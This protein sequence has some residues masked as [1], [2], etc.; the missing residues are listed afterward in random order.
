MKNTTIELSVSLKF[1]V[2]ADS[3]LNLCIFAAVYNECGPIAGL[4]DDCSFY[5]NEDCISP[6]PPRI[7]SSATPSSTITYSSNYIYT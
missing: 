6:L 1:K 2:I 3:F 4:G 5:P 7:Q